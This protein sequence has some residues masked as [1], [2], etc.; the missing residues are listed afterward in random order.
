[1][2]KF[3]V[4][5]S[6]ETEVT[7]STDSP[8]SDNLMLYHIGFLF[9]AAQGAGLASAVRTHLVTGYESTIQKIYW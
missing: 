3:P 8:F 7:T 1:M 5:K 2:D 4:P 9:Q 6:W